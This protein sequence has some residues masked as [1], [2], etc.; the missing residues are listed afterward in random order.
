MSDDIENLA[1]RQNGA[2]NILEAAEH[3]AALLDLPSVGV[4]IR[5]AHVVGQGSRASVQIALSNGETLE[6]DTVRDMVRPQNLIAEVAACTGATPTLKQPQA[7]RAVALVRA[8]AERTAGI[9]ANDEARTWGIEY[10]QSADTLDV[11]L[12]DQGGRWAVFK[13]LDGVDPYTTARDKGAPFAHA[14]VVLRHS[15]GSRL[16]RTGWFRDYVKREQDHTVSPA[17]LHNRMQ[18]VGWQRRG[19]HGRIKATCP[20]RRDSLQWNFYIVPTDWLE[21]E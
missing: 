10:L 13:H 16:V 21:A 9:T 18:R 2:L 6:W 15:D 11:D 14:T 7:V 1:H 17:Q 19:N 20:G 3:L 4:E 5:G 12:N 8:L